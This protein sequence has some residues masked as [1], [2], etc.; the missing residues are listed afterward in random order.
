MYN[1]L[2]PFYLFTW[3]WLTL[4][5]AIWI[6]WHSLAKVDF[7]Y[8]VWYDHGGIKEH[9]DKF[10]PKNRYRNDYEDTDRETRLANFGGIVHAIQNHGEG[11]DKLSY[12]NQ[13]GTIPLLHKAEI[14]H[15]QD[16][17]NLIDVLNR[18][19]TSFAII[20]VMLTSILML[21]QSAFPSFKNAGF[22]IGTGILLAII[23]IFSYGAT[24]VFYQFHVWVF[25]ADNQWFFY[26]QDSLMSTM[27]KAPDIFGMIAV[28][29]LVFSLLIFFLIQ[30]FF[31]KLTC[32]FD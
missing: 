23:L 30:G 10:A 4:L 27:M 21:R 12:K 32:N 8:S 20:W 1:M 7:L 29:L 19:F 22:N 18:L 16:V 11:L 26:Y 17:A 2:K 6:S 9:I 13:Y 31:Y 3:S 15:L 28:T 5:L 25:P 24:E 14:V